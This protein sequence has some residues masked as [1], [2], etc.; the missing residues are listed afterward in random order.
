MA[1]VTKRFQKMV[2]R[3]RGIPK[4]GSSNKPRVYDLC[5]KC[6][7]L[8]H[9]IKDCP[10]L[11]QDQYKHNTDKAAKRNPVPDKRFK[12][13]DIAE[14]VV[15]QALAAWGDS[16]SESREDD[17][18]SDTSMMAIESEA[19]EYDSIFALMAKYDDGKDDDDDEV[20]FLDVQRNL[21]SYSQKKLISLP[22][23]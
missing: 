16:S 1:Y 11:K 20:N 21:K 9:F 15:K 22:I 17:E 6:G 23:F 5:H 7:K 4:K 12:R 14:N 8:G 2:R 19:A 10:L 3:N 18:Q 13:K